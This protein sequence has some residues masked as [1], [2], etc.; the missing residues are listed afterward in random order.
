MISSFCDYPVVGNIPLSSVTWGELLALPRL[1]E[2]ETPAGATT[3][4]DHRCWHRCEACPSELCC[5]NHSCHLLFLQ[6]P[7][8]LTSTAMGT[9]GTSSREGLCSHI[10]HFHLFIC[11]S[12]Y[13][14]IILKLHYFNFIFVI[15]LST[16]DSL[17]LD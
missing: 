3:A 5:Q 12:V 6:K 11:L 16:Q 17:E 15:P 4:C 2:D 14:H 13:Y 7:K 9:A 10:L 8:A 1:S